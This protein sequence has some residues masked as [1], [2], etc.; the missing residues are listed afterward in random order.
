VIV[1]VLGTTPETLWPARGFF[2]AFN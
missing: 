2:I 1:D